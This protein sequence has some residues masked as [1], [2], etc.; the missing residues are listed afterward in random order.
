M[1]D[2]SIPTGKDGGELLCCENC[3]SAYHLQCTNP[4]LEDVPN[5]KWQCERCAVSNYRW[6][7]R[8]V[9]ST[10]LPTLVDRIFDSYL[11]FG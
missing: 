3:T 11:T 5:G 4:P 9:I 8:S 6:F 1:T 2:L 10:F 7:L